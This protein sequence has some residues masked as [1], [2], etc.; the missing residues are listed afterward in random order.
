MRLIIMCKAPVTGRVKTRLQPEFTAEEAAAI[1]RAMA[2]TVIHRA[3][4]L[5]PHATIA[6]DWPEHPFFQSFSLPVVPQGDGDLGA[7][8][9]GLMQQHF[10]ERH[11]PL[12]FIGTDSPHMADERLLQAAEAV[13]HHQVVLGPVEDGGYD[14]IAL[15]GAYHALFEAID[16][17]SERVLQQSLHAICASALSYQLLAPAFDIDTAADLQRAAGMF[18]YEACL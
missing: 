1:H 2:A 12:I 15:S 9:G 14:L 6:A 8:M 10:A 3:A 11:D 16:W 13:R 17:G 4:R 18:D 5:F 7:R